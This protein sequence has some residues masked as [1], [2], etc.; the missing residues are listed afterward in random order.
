MGWKRILSFLLDRDE[1]L[2]SL[3]AVLMSHA[4]IPLKISMSLLLSHAASKNL[5]PLLFQDKNKYP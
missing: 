4:A 3:D 1:A 5:K 2:S